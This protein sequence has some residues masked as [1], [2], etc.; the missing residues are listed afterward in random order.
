MGI[1]VKV[2]PAVLIPRADTENLCVQAL[3][4]MQGYEHVLDL[5]TGS[6]AIALAIKRRMPQA[7]VTASDLSLEAILLARENAA[8]LGLDIT[9][10]QGDLFAPLPGMIFDMILCNPPYI[11]QRDGATLQEELMYEP[12]MAL[13]GGVDGLDFYRRIVRD[14]PGYLAS[15]GQLMLEL[16][17]GQTEEIL[18]LME[19]GFSFVTVYKDLSGLNRVV[20]GTRKG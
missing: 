15:G 20:T 12:P 14:A 18:A 5:C 16:G 19:D 9:F 8:R 3:L 11:P 7:S 13:F 6:G 17:D 4:R 1:P 2:T 10:M